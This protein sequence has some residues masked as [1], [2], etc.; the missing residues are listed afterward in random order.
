MGLAVTALFVFEAGWFFRK[1]VSVPKAQDITTG[2][3]QWACPKSL[4]WKIL[5]YNLFRSI[6]RFYTI[7]KVKNVVFRENLQFAEQL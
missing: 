5:S 2:V 7:L 3:L 4:R 1:G 6:E